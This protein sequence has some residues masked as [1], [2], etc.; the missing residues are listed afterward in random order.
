[1]DETA[2]PA[3]EQLA[4]LTR[5]IGGAVH[6][7]ALSIIG[8]AGNYEMAVQGADVLDTGIPHDAL[9]ALLAIRSSCA[10]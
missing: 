7:L 10:R 1:M 3:A 5:R 9:L 6:A 8:P 4:T 2:R